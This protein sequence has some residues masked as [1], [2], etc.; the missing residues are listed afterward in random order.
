QD[1]LGYKNR[2]IFSPKQFKE[3]ILPYFTRLYQAARKK[4]VFIV[5]HACG[6]LH[7]VLPLLA[8]A[9]LHC[10]QSVQQTA[11][12]DLAYLKEIVGDRIAFMG[13]LDDSRTLGFGTPEDVEND[14]KKC[15]RILGPTGNFCPGPSNTILDPPWENI[16]AMINSLEKYRSYPLKV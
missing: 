9:G 1:D 5:H 13:C 7:E 14:V 12:N 8:D 16:M 15:I 2:S 4:G 6:Y 10:I 3:F 11:G